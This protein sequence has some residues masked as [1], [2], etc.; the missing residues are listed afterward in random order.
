MTG[1]STPPVVVTDPAGPLP[2]GLA[3]SPPAA[4]ALVGGRRGH[5]RPDVLG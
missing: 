2:V 4:V 5:R 3:G 1:G